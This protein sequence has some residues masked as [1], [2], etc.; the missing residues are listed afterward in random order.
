MKR[1]LGALFSIN[2]EVKAKHKNKIKPA[3]G[4]Q[5]RNIEIYKQIDFDIGEL[6]TK[7]KLGAE[8]Q[9]KVNNIELIKAIL[10]IVPLPISTGQHVLWGKNLVV[11]FP[12]AE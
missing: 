3:D 9:N 2:L 11:I 7:T 1:I 4:L 10:N 6:K 8:K 12:S 5:I